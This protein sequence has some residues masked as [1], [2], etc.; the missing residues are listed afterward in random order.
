MNSRQFLVKITEK[1]PVKVLS[2]AAA[3]LLSVF[4]RINTLE[5]RFLSAPLRIEANDTLVPASSFTQI[6]R[7]SLRGEGNSIYPILDDDIEAYI[8]LKKYANEGLYRVPVQIRKKGSAVGV[9][10]L[11]ISVEPM[12]IAINLENRLSRNINIMPVFHGNVA[13]GYELANQSITPTIVIAEGPRSSMELLYE[14]YT[15]TIDLDGRF[16]DFSVMVNII[17]DNPLIQIHGNRMV[18]YRGVIKR[19]VRTVQVNNPAGENEAGVNEQ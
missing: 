2:V 11:E 13:D 7:V 12:E 9:E 1:W 5:S 14:F 10:P 19:I 17:N 4:H 18:E 16:Q 8:D 15:G 6:V 3:L